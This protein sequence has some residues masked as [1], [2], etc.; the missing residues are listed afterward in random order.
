MRIECASRPLS[1]SEDRILFHW[2]QNIWQMPHVRPRWR[3]VKKPLHAFGY[4]EATDPG[5]RL[6]QLVSHVAGCVHT[7]RINGRSRRIG[8]IGGVVTVP[9]AQGRGYARQLTAAIL[10]TLRRQ[11]VLDA[12]VLLCLPHL[13]DFYTRLG[14]QVVAVPFTLQHPSGS[15]PSP[16]LAF[17]QPFVDLGPIT[18]FSVQGRPW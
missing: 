18:Q 10:T 8:A 17:V 1:E 9:E 13:A 11:A 5:L 3:F 4:A 16:F 6:D 15:R 7:C 14:W 12:G 2:D